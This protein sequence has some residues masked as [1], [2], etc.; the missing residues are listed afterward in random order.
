MEDA[1]KNGHWKVA[2]IFQRHA[3]VMESRIEMVENAFAK[4][5]SSGQLK[6]PDSLK[7]R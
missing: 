4:S 1:K 5:D 7:S 3:S 6:V 2:E